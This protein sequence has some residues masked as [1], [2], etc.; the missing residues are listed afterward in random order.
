MHPGVQKS[1]RES[2][3]TLP[4]ELPF[5][6]LDSQMDSQIFRGRLQGSKLIGWKRSLYH[7]KYFGM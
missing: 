1:V 7:W 2:T 4:S 6:E 3:L 5:S